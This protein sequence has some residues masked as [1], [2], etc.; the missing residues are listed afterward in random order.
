MI[1]ISEA[2]AKQIFLKAASVL[3]QQ[4]ARIHELELE[5]AQRLRGDHAEKIAAK[6]VERGIMDEDEAESYAQ[7]LRDSD[8]DLSIVE[9]V[10]GHAA[11]HAPV[12]DLLKQAAD[13]GSAE[14]DVLTQYLLTTDLP[15]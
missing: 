12:G 5:K 2:E 6:A 11:A 10:V 9:D 8:K 7:Q 1:K 13:V 15:A 4:E 3:R 14:Q